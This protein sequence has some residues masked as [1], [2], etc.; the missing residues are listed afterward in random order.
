MLSYND[1]VKVIFYLN[2][3]SGKINVNFSLTYFFQRLT[4]NPLS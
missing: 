1:K 3:T 4:L 2:E